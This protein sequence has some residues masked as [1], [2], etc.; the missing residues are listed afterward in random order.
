[1]F[2][3]FPL[4]EVY[5]LLEPGPVVLLTTAHHGKANVMSMPTLREKYD[6]LRLRAQ[7]EAE[8]KRGGR[9]DQRPPLPGSGVWERPVDLGDNE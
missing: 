4:A 5:Q 7:E 6:T 1:M 3:D 8:R 2:K 9:G